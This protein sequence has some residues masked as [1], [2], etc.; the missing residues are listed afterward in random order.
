MAAKISQE[1]IND[2]KYIK[3]LLKFY[4][5]KDSHLFMDIDKIQLP[6]SRIKKAMKHLGVDKYRL[7]GIEKIGL[8]D[9]NGA[10]ASSILKKLASKTTYNE[11]MKYRK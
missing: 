2:V 10:L 11:I 5:N 9:K 4:T 8:R 3:T 7:L 6:K 1:T